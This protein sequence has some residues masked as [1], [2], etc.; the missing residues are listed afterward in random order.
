M[1]FRSYLQLV[2]ETD[3][4]LSFDTSVRDERNMGESVKHGPGAVVVGVCGYRRGRRD[5]I[6]RP[7]LRINIIPL[8]EFLLP[9]E[10]MSVPHFRGAALRYTD[11]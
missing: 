1:Q 8:L 10:Q 4:P 11:V 5:M 9:Q 6:E 3:F 7:A 2:Y